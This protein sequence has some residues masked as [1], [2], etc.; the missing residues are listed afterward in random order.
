MRYDVKDL[1]LAR[2]G[3]LRIEW[4]NEYMPVLAL[5][6]KNWTRL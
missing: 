4:A 5:I 2:K 1:S 6:R 3:R